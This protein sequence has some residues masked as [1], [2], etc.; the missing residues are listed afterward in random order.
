MAVIDNVLT[1][2]YWGKYT[3]L[4]FRQADRA[5]SWAKPDPER[6]KN[7]G[8]Q[9]QL[10]LVSRSHT[11]ELKDYPQRKSYYQFF[12][13]NTKPHFEIISFVER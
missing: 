10:L 6:S 5:A 3:R 1:F 7:R 8:T 13:Q 11:C 9:L 12:Q 2:A 4:G